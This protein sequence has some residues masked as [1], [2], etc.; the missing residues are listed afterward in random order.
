METEGRTHYS[1]R[2]S[3]GEI[4]HQR[5]YRCLL[6]GLVCTALIVIV[7]FAALLLAGTGA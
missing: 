3:R 2:R 1:V 7:V 6:W 4:R 5:R